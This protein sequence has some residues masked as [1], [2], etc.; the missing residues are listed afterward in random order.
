MRLI[1]KLGFLLLISTAIAGE[2]EM[3]RAIT[4]GDLD[5][6]QTLVTQVDN[7]DVSDHTG[8]TL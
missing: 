8:K 7:I 1:L 4:N 6:I 2:E 5:G 3:I